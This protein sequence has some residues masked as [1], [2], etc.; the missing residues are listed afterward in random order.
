[1]IKPVL[2]IYLNRQR[3]Q[4]LTAENS[5]KN[6]TLRGILPDEKRTLKVARP[7]HKV[8]ETQP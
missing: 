8:G 6:P 1:M 5:A 3:N 2:S 7:F 4:G